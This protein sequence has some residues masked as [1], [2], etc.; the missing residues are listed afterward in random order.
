M[1]ELEGLKEVFKGLEEQKTQWETTAEEL[2]NARAA[3]DPDVNPD[4]TDDDRQTADEAINSH[5]ELKQDIIDAYGEAMQARDDKENLINEAARMREDAEY[6]AIKQEGDEAFYD[7]EGL[8]LDQ[9]Y[10][11]EAFQDEANYWKH[12]RFNALAND[13]IDQFNEFEEYYQAALA[14]VEKA[15]AKYETTDAK[16]QIEKAAKETRDRDEEARWIQ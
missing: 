5:E 7:L 4:A 13:D 8:L 1:E 9:Q 6:Q 12:E 11:V 15:Q 2:R 16:Y 3:L 14:N 10:Q